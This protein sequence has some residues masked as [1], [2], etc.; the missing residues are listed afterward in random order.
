MKT[1]YEGIFRHRG[2][3]YHKAMTDFPNARSM[4]FQQLFYRFPLG[5]RE[6]IIDCPALG[7]YL[8]SSL[9]YSTWGITVESLDF[10]PQSP[11]VTPISNLASL[12]LGADRVICLAA[13]HHI[14]DLP[15][16][17]ES[18]A[19]PLRPLGKLHLADVGNNNPIRHF[20]DDFVGRWTS[21]GHNG[22]WRSFST[23]SLTNLT[24]SL[25]LAC[26]EERECPWVFRNAEEMIRFCR[27]LFG[28][29]LNPSDSQIIEAL[30]EYV[31]IEEESG[32]VRVKWRLNYADFYKNA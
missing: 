12:E 13:S 32:V 29:D 10:C 17:L 22:I 20:L 31:G 9:P 3:S 25:E 4:E 26:V 15:G 14:P 16:F 5:G 23:D 24:P 1:D 30:S 2:A 7:A 28:L 11:N 19:A 18:L 21:T 8:L 27:L 6:R